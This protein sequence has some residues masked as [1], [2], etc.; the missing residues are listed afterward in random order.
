MKKVIALGFFD[1]VHLGHGALLRRAVLRAAELGAVPAA[2]TFDIHP[3]QVI[4]GRDMATLSTPEDRAD[5]MARLYGIQ[6]VLVA[7]FDQKMMEM[8]WDAFVSEYLVREN[9]VCHVVVGHDYRFGYRGEG[10]PE[11]LKKLCEKLKIGCDVVER[12]TLDGVTVSSTYIRGLV[13]QG[14]MERANRFLGH[15]HC[16][17]G[18]VEHG[19][20]LGS[21][22]GF[23]TVNITMPQ[24]VLVPAHGVY[25]AKAWYLPG[26]GDRGSAPASG[27]AE[28][29]LAV[30][31]IGVRPSIQDGDHVTVESFLLDFD[32][33]L[34]GQRV[35]LELFHRLRPERAFDTLEELTQEVARNAQQT[36]DYFGK[37]DEAQEV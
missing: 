36:R 4:F 25:A 20:K 28:C 3:E 23:P 19:K 7:H 30:T 12:V 24:G 35:R 15:P 34:Y 2:C 6:E 14:E 13:A 32:Q 18:R 22:L 37:R 1:G 21:R 16:L 9:Q 5:M 8:P 10:D 17:S 26:A 27:G 31:N 33:D 11:K 29:R